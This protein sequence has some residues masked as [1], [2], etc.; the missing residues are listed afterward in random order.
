M[1][2]RFFGQWD[3]PVDKVLYENYFKDVESGTF[4]DCGAAEGALYSNTFAFEREANWTGL[5]LEPSPK[6]FAELIVNRPK[7]TNLNI[8]LSNK[9]GVITFTQAVHPV[10]T[11]A[12]LPAGGAVSYLPNLKKEIGAW[13]YNFSEIPINVL[14]YRTMV[15]KYNIIKVDLLVIDVEGHEMSVIEGM[16]GASVL[17]KVICIEYPITGINKI[18]R[19][20]TNL[21]YRLDFV[22]YNNAFFSNGVESKEW[23]GKTKLW[24]GC[25]QDD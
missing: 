18:T 15:T 4:I 20:L 25:Y 14:T 23:F 6:A 3:I 2:T 17:P 1:I 19:A 24:E 16:V 13:G 9:D 5:C 22:S 12:G 11:G 21:G 8:G 10:G 7:A